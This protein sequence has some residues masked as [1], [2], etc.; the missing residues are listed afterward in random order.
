MES[1]KPIAGYEGLYEVSDFGNVRSVDRYINTDIR[2]VSER[3]IKGRQLKTNLKRN[4]YLTVDLSKGCKIKTTLIHRLVAET[5]I[6]NPNGLRFVN[7]KDS[8]RKN[9]RADNLEWVTS[10]ENRLHGMKNGN[11]TFKGAQIMCVE[12][13]KVFDRALLAAE[14]VAKKHPGRI[15]GGLRVA[16]QNIRACCKGNKHTAYGF[17]W[18]YHEGSTTIPKGSTPKRVEMGSTLPDHAGGKDIV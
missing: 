3:L 8:N 10:S 16:A 5:F 18:Q 11:V 1:W 13:K 2:H 15:N 14:W 9:N 4:G 12:K 17:T 6:P 7:H